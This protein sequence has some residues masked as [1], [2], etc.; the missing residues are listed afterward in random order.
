MAGKVRGRYEIVKANPDSPRGMD[1]IADVRQ[2]TSSGLLGTRTDNPVRV[3]DVV[4]RSART[5]Q[6]KTRNMERTLEASARRVAGKFPKQL[7]GR[8][9]GPVGALLT[10]DP[11]DWVNEDDVIDKEGNVNTEPLERGRIKPKL[12]G[13]KGPESEMKSGGKVA[14]KAKGGKVVPRGCG[15]AMRGYG[16]AMKGK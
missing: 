12:R 2:N 11:E 14:Y 9:A 10:T 16:K 3:G 15:V 6:V 8:A 13:Y 7:L 1:N 4:G 5:G